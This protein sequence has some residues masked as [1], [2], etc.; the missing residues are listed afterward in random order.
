MLLIYTVLFVWVVRHRHC[1]KKLTKKSCLRKK[2][3]KCIVTLLFMY[4]YLYFYFIQ[5]S[6]FFFFGISTVVNTVCMKYTVKV[7]K[8]NLIYFLF[9]FIIKYNFTK[10]NAYF[11]TTCF[12]ITLLHTER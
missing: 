5:R 3:A 12:L 1:D 8:T 11:F 6:Q 2:N 10:F 9:N 4:L 7:F